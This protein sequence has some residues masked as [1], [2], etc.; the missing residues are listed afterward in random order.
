MMLEKQ[1][2]KSSGNDSGNFRM[3]D[4]EPEAMKWLLE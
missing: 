2:E 1:L 3:F 4:S